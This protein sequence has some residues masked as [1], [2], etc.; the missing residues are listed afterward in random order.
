MLVG[1]KKEL[2]GWSMESTWPLGHSHNTSRNRLYVIKFVSWPSGQVGLEYL[3]TKHI[4]MQ[5]DNKRD[6][7]IDQSSLI[8]IG[9]F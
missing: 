1:N 8:W 2:G 7:P 6:I 9:S 3:A 4:L 5:K